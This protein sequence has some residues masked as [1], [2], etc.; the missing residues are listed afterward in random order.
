M[1]VLFDICGALR[2]SS[3]MSGVPRYVKSAQICLERNT[4]ESSSI[5]FKRD[6][7]T[8]KQAWEVHMFQ[9][10]PTYVQQRCPNM[11]TKEHSR[12]GVCIHA[13]KEHVLLPW[14]LCTYVGLFC[15]I[16]NHRTL[17][18]RNFKCRFSQLQVHIHTYAG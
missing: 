17:G 8:C 11:S 6:P 10:R 3:K 2:G 4:H 15:H 14:S 16:W 1:W 5:R 13:G 9:M 18:P 7:Y 12:D